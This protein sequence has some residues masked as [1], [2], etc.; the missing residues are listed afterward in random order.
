VRVVNFVSQG[1]I[2][3]GMLS[4]LKF[5]KSLFAG[6]LDGGEK[7]VFL[8]GS[9]LNRFIETVEKAT[10]SIPQ[11]VAQDPPQP[12]EDDGEPEHADAETTGE[13]QAAPIS[14]PPL[15][16]P[17]AGLL[18][19]GLALIEQLAAA[20]RAGAALPSGVALSGGAS[21]PGLSLIH[22]D[23]RTGENYF[24]IPVPNPELLD[25]VLGAVGALLDRFR[26]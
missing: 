14:A 26:K 16:G 20:S 5:K 17:W 3:E 22:R 7:E 4:I 6:A 8:G 15:G 19:T 21:S 25:Q 2:E 24:K 10:S 12:P 1:T 18:Q 9:R 23:D 13:K 11:P